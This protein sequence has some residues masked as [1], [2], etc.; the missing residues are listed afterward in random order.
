M[1]ETIRIEEDTS[2]PRIR[3]M[4]ERINSE[5]LETQGRK[6]DKA[7]VSEVVSRELK[8][9]FDRVFRDVYPAGI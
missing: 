3:L 2:N 9:F 7:Q 5:L 1:Q 4:R 6:P 8:E